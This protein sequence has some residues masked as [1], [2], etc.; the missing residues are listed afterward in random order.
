[1]TEQILTV[2]PGQTIETVAVLAAA[3]EIDHDSRDVLADAAAA[4][5]RD[6]ASRLVLDLA[7]VSFC[8]SGGLSLF[9]DLHRDTAARGGSLRLARVQPTVL[10]VIHATNLDRLLHL[11]PTVEAAVHASRAED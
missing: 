4:V 11:D 10:A 2:D 3:G 8:D 6:G 7:D 5:L 9:L 1:M